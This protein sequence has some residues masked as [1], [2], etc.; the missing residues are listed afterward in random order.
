ML[1]HGVLVYWEA[2][3]IALTVAEDF[4]QQH[5]ARSIR[6]S[7]RPVPEENTRIQRARLR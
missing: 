4:T 6:K 5:W 1:E 2:I 3:K 7:A